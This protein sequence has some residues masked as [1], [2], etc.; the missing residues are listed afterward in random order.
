[1]KNYKFSSSAKSIWAIAILTASALLTS[2]S[3]N[4]DGQQFLPS[5]EDQALLTLQQTLPETLVIFNPDEFYPDGTKSSD[6]G[7]VDVASS[8]LDYGAASFLSDDRYD[9]IQI[10]IDTRSPFSAAYVSLP[11]YKDGGRGSVTATGKTYL[12]S[13]TSKDTAAQRLST[14]LPLYPILI[15]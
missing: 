15:S 13:Q 11:G 6:S 7:P 9:Y 1:M 8:S 5:S 10:P 3:K 4:E 12:V 2:C 14:S